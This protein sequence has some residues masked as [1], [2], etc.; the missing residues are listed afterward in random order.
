MDNSE[1][2]LENDLSH[3]N[4]HRGHELRDIGERLEEIEFELESL[5]LG[6]EG[7]LGFAEYEGELYFAFRIDYLGRKLIRYGKVPG[8]VQ[9]EG[10]QAIK[11]NAEGRMKASFDA[12]K[13]RVDEDVAFER[14]SNVEVSVIHDEQVLRGV[15]LSGDGRYFHLRMA[16]PYEIERERCGGYNFAS[17][18]S[19]RFMFDRDSNGKLCYSADCI[20]GAERELIRMYEEKKYALRNADTI[21]LVNKLNEK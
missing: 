18:M 4:G 16:H 10:E 2:D 17:A 5:T 9:S 3:F 13:K 1:I 6:D 7:G 20:E 11:R 12:F 19:K 14:H 15:I 8:D 21:A